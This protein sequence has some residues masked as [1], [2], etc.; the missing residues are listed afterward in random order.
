VDSP[1]VPSWFTV[2]KGHQRIASS[3]HALCHLESTLRSFA[4]GVIC[5]SCTLLNGD[6]VTPF[7][8]ELLR[9]A[10]IDHTQRRLSGVFFWIFLVLEGVPITGSITED[11]LLRLKF[12][13]RMK[14]SGVFDNRTYCSWPP[15]W[16]VCP[17]VHCV[18]LTCICFTNV[19]RRICLLSMCD[20]SPSGF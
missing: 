6:A 17:K 13:S 7:L 8:P 14:S 1:S 20:C 4:E 3:I 10:A 12:R 19:I 18:S 16:N 11:S 2:A 9:L 15:L 5:A